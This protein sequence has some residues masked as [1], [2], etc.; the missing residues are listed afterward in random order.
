MKLM[1]I[2]KSYKLLIV[3]VISIIFVSLTGCNSPKEK[4]VD[5][6][7]FNIIDERANI[8]GYEGSKKNLIIPRVLDDYQVVSIE[9]EAFA[10]LEILESIEIPNTISK[11]GEHAFK[12][13][14]NLRSVTFEEK[15]KLTKIEKG[16]FYNANSLVDIIIPNGIV[17]IDD[18]AFYKAT[19]LSSIIF[20]YSLEEIKERAFYGTDNLKVVSF[21]RYN[22]VIPAL[23]TIGDWAFASS[24]LE[25][26][27]MP[28][29]IQTIG[30]NAFRGAHNL[31]AIRFYDHG[32]LTTIGSN[33]FNGAKSLEK[34]IIPYKTTIIGKDAFKGASKLTIFAATDKPRQNWDDDWNASNRPVYWVNEF[35]Y[36][37]DGMPVIIN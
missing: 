26:F 27:D 8:L 10:N 15:S 11:V 5:G 31:K 9:K 6:F 24:S 23:T 7:R 16:V 3:L 4:I 29:T 36:D 21:E 20:P 22:R 1:K 28:I 33:A 35:R 25:S 30:D 13:A 12:D 19:S 14:H 34:I 18:Y 32:E 2:M 37:D 17:A